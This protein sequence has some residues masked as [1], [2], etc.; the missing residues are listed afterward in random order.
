[1]RIYCMKMLLEDR[2]LGRADS[3]FHESQDL[4]PPAGEL[5][6]RRPTDLQ[7]REE[8]APRSRGISKILLATDFSPSSTKALECAVALARQLAASLTVL[9]VID[10]NPPEASTHA[11]DAASLMRGLRVHAITEMDRLASSLAGEQV[12]TQ[13]MLV[14]GLPPQEILNQS[15]HSDLV[16]LGTQPTK[17]LWSLFSKHTA[18]HVIEAAHCPVL[19]VRE[20]TGS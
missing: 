12:R 6:A 18:Q 5:R 2:T 4:A 9:H 13:P 3:W 1:M 17:R 19:V 16:V 7:S 15:K 20:E 8:N 10:I 11:G 14:E